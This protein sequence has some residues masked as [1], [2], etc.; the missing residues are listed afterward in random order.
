MDYYQLLQLEREPFSNSPDPDYF[1][2]SQQHRACLQKLELALRLKRGLNVVLGDVGTGKTTLCR[3]LIRKFS[4]DKTFETHLIL[5]PATDTPREF[6]LVIADMLCK[7]VLDRSLSEPEIKERIKQ[8]LFKKGVDQGKTIILI[9]DEGQKIASA[10]VEILRELLNY[11]TNEYKL[12]Q[13]VLFAQNEFNDTLEKHANFADRINVLHHLPPMGFSDTCRMIRHRL[14]QSSS[15][16]KPMNLFT[17]PALWAIYQTSRGYPRR[18]IHICHQS[19]LAMIIQNKT[20]AG[21]ATIRSCKK[22]IAASPRPGRRWLQWL[23]AGMAGAV[24]AGA[25]LLIPRQVNHGGQQSFP[26]IFK[27]AREPAADLPAPAEEP[28]QATLPAAA[29]MTDP[30]APVVEQPQAK[31]DTTVPVPPEPAETIEP[32]N[33]PGA[34]PT[35]EPQIQENQAAAD[36]DPPS[37]LGRLRVQPGDTI[38]D[39]VQQVYG[40]YRNQILAAVLEANPHIPHPDDIVPGDDILFPALPFRSLSKTT[41]NYWL[42][43]DDAPDLAQARE[44]LRRLG[45]TIE[46]PLRL[47]SWWSPKDGLQFHVA[48]K[49]TF[50][51][52]DKAEQFLGTLPSGAADKALMVSHWNEDVQLFCE[53]YAGFRR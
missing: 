30:I 43:L 11:E 28:V 39:M 9:I 4:L 10:N 50:G 24:V 31:T 35:V 51:S 14:K 37:A 46:T 21:W 2:Q 53:P 49:G 29:S 8:I 22:R 27:I 18:I 32:L 17:K 47:I 15:T 38:G 3:E 20:R 12:L 19:M 6:L 26:Q 45:R 16:P 40:T 33:P 13:I 41:E 5:D 25:I 34:T 7:D 48:V 52:S 44:R 1:F 42:L 23:L 36:P